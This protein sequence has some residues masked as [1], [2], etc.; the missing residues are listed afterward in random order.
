MDHT[1]TSLPRLLSSTHRKPILTL[2]ELFSNISTVI[3]SS[4]SSSSSTVDSTTIPGNLSTPQNCRKMGARLELRWISTLRIP[5]RGHL[6]RTCS[7]QLMGEREKAMW[8]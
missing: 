4:S 3:S 7:R 8:M 6:S 1:E 2:M 5:S